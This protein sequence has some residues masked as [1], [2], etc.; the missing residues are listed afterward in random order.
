MPRVKYCFWLFKIPAS[1]KYN[2]IVSPFFL[3]IFQFVSGYQ[4][5]SDFLKIPVRSSFE[6]FL[7]EIVSNRMSPS[8]KAANL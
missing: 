1:K 7:G 8:E 3:E 5:L 2:F 6:G 4:F